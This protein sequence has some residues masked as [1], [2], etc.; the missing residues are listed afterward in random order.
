V[1]ELISVISTQERVARHS[2]CTS[3]AVKRPTPPTCLWPLGA[4][5]RR[6]S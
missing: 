6:V 1:M 2:R 4:A 5:V 3:I